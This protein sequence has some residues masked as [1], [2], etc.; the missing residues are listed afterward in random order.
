MSQSKFTHKLCLT[1]VLLFVLST[2]FAP[3][4]LNAQTSTD[5]EGDAANRTYLPVVMGDTTQVEASA[6]TKRKIDTITGTSDYE[7]FGF[8]DSRK[9]VRDSLGNLY[10]AFRKPYKVNTT[11][12]LHIFVAKSTDNGVTWTVP[13][14]PVDVAIGDYNQ[15]HP[16]LAIDS[17]D[18]L[19]LVWYGLDKQNAKTNNRQIKYARSTDRGA[20][21]NLPGD[22]QGNIAL[23]T[24]YNNEDYWQEH[25]VIFINSVNTI[26]VAWEG[27]DANN[28]A[29][30]QV[31]LIKSVNG[32]TSWSSW[33]NIAQDGS[34][35]FSRP[36]MIADNANSSLLY[37][38]A[39]ANGFGSSNNIVWTKSTD[40]G[41]NWI[42]W[43]ALSSSSKQ[44]KSISVAIDS[45]NRI[46]TVW[47][48]PP[49]TGTVTN[50]FYS[51]F[52]NNA[53]SAPIALSPS[54]SRYQY[55]PSIAVDSTD[56]VW[57][58]WSDCGGDTNCLAGDPINGTSRFMVKSAAGWGASQTI[59]TSSALFPTLR[60][61]KATTTTIIDSV[62]L[63]K[64]TDGSI[65][66]YYARLN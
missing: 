1:I 12:Q 47:T 17:N 41:S 23:V 65:E 11:T 45:Q 44:Q 66:L 57:V 50:T 34:K 28:R 24:G 19:H 22:S 54:T 35:R 16:S 64:R 42:A 14:K 62:W 25:P 13:A 60:R 31:K 63:E 61:A 46:H 30:R 40:G 52:Q 49:N 56:K 59:S 2:A 51:L 37:A 53:W 8:P 36:T 43:S 48:Q 10:V 29:N 32:G 3:F 27:A 38:F 15:R 55:F 4:A 26:Y 18:V 7:Q 39:Y 9:I 33:M 5:D 20:T 58:T 21:W 6:I